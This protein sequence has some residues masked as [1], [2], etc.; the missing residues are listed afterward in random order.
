M[1]GYFLLIIITK[2]INM[3]L[4]MPLREMYGDWAMLLKLL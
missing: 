1:E 4:D 3:N 2:I